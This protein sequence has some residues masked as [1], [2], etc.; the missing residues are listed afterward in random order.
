MRRIRKGAFYVRKGQ[1]CLSHEYIHIIFIISFQ[2]QKQFSIISAWI[3][4]VH[5][6]QINAF[7]K[8]FHKKIIY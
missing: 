8:I 7:L 4:F 1:M 5:E 2:Q 3:I 6:L